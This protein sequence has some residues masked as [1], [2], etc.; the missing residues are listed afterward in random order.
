MVDFRWDVTE[1]RSREKRKN[2]YGERDEGTRLEL[3]LCR[4]Q[5]QWCSLVEALSA[6]Q[7]E[8]RKGS[9]LPKVSF[10]CPSL[11]CLPAQAHL[12]QKVRSITTLK[13]NFRKTLII[14]NSSILEKKLNTDT[15]VTWEL[16]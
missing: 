14:N 2:N 16:V 1:G 11:L 9:H 15:Y 12:Q 10:C 5:H 3:E 7:E 4:K 6:R 13:I 8:R